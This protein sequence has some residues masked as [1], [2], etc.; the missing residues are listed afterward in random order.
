MQFFPDG[1]LFDN[2]VFV[3]NNSPQVE[4]V[5]TD[6]ASITI[7]DNFYEDIVSVNRELSKIPITKVFHQYSDNGVTY[8]DGRKVYCNNM[9]GTEIPYTQDKSLTSKVGE[10]INYP[11]SSI[12]IDN[13]I[14]INCFQFTDELSLSDSYYSVH[15]DPYTCD[16]P[17]QTA[18][19]V[20][21]NDHYEDGEGMN[22]YSKLYGDTPFHSDNSMVLKKDIDLIYTVQGKCNR[23]VLFDSKFTHGQ[24]TPTDQFKK[25]MRYT[26]V[27]F[28]PLY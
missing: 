7:I 21:L 16:S 9:Q 2:N 20:F 11:E 12:E 19:V 6:R 27:I 8:F 26:Q 10:Y 18:M 3:I 4:P 14:L 13:K 22:F 5:E 25:E 28:F 24:H 17:G 15:E 23:A 1:E